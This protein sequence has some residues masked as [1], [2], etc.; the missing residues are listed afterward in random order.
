[1]CDFKRAERDLFTSRYA[2]VGSKRGRVKSLPADKCR[3]DFQ[4]DAHRIIYSQ[5]FRRLKHKTQ[6]F[7]FP[8]NDHVS[9]RSEHVLLVA[10]ASRSVARC[11]GLNEDLAEAIGLGHDI[12]HAPFGHEGER[13]LN[14]IIQERSLYSHRPDLVEDLVKLQQIMPKFHHEIYGLRVVDK[15]A[16]RDRE[17]PGLNLTWEVRD[18]ILSHYGEDRKARLVRPSKGE[19]DLSA[20]RSYKDA[21]TPA[22]LEGCLVRMIDRIAYA[23]RD[24]EDAIRV[25]IIKAE[26]VPEQLQEAAGPNNGAVMRSFLEDLVENSKDKNEI[27]ISKKMGQLLTDLLQFNYTNIYE[28]PK[29]QRYKE[30][31]LKVL[32]L[33][34]E[35]L[36]AYLGD[37]DATR[38]TY[39]SG[40]S[41]GNGTPA[42]IKVF[43]EFLEDMAKGDVYQEKDPPSLKVLDFLAGMTDN[44]AVKSFQDLFVP[45][46]TV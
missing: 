37:P 35:E 23:G 30:R 21:G 24:I 4:R 32:V 25:N 11:L 38:A 46:A 17:K 16:T 22:T 15:L 9:T 41:N 29:A 34:F 26:D 28:S 6:V 5:A 13:I 1:M 43:D 42:V 33:L 40:E 18:G 44:F 19:K 27:A 20:V 7:Y 10:S 39:A 2:T 14:R 12:G 36:W 31:A 45:R 3:T 8:E